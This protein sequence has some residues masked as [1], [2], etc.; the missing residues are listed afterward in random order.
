MSGTINNLLFVALVVVEMNLPGHRRS[1]S[2]LLEARAFVSARGATCVQ[3]P[4]PTS[5]VPE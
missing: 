3:L 1:I 5:S 2:M 4:Y